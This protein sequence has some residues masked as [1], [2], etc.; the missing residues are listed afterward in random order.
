MANVL[1]VIRTWFKLHTH[2]S[3]SIYWNGEPVCKLP[4]HTEPVSNAEHTAFKK[5]IELGYIPAVPE[6]TCPWKYFADN[7]IGYST[8]VIEVGLKKN[9]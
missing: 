3:V 6:H 9:L 1:F 8:E 7:N 5:L 4:I 2:T